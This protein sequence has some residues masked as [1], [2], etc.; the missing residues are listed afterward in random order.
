VDPPA[1]NEGLHALAD[2]T[3]LLSPWF[4]D[5]SSGVAA[6]A[7]EAA[8]RFGLD[9]EQSKR[10]ECAGLVHDIGRV[11]ITVSIWDAPRPLTTS[12]S[13]RV[14]MH[15]LL[16]ERILGRASA[17]A[18]VAEL[19]ALAHER[20]DGTGYHRCLPPNALTPAA[21][22]LAASDCYR[23][24]CEDRPH[25]SRL[26]SD[27]AA[28]DLRGLAASGSLDADA[29]EAVVAAAG[30]A[31][32]LRRPRPGK[33]T[34]RELEVIRLLARGLT[35]KEI[36][37]GKPPRP[38]ISSRGEAAARSR[39]R[40]RTARLRASP[41]HPGRTGSGRALGHVGPWLRNRCP[42][43]GPGCSHPAAT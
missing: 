28:K 14:Q 20:L 40:N 25:R 41:P 8:T 19:A 6:L 10:V 23:A 2:F 29:V 22:I 30:H 36:A 35:N 31:P 18:P 17:L 1:V 7:K 26:D 32:R 37:S 12:E 5:H 15:T 21:R 33:L 24:M 13:E 34:D 3:D 39:S 27:R 9:D 43:A 16:T 42:L 4:R 38:R 11:G